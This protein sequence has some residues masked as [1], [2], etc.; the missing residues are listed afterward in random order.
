MM[1]PL[2]QVVRTLEFLSRHTP[3]SLSD[4]LLLI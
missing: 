4:R 3:H 1:C 2:E